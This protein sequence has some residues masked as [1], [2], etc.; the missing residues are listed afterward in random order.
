MFTNLNQLIGFVIGIVV[1]IV[2]IILWLV[3]K[4]EIFG[5]FR[6]G[7]LSS[8]IRY[9]DFLKENNQ[10]RLDNGQNKILVFIIFILRLMRNFKRLF[11]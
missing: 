11:S 4:D 2:P 5:V 6:Q 1:F 8:S 3:K 7:G 9:I 10:I